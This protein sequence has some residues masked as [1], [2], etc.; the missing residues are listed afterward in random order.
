[1]KPIILLDIDDTVVDM[2]T[3]WKEWYYKESGY[4]L[5]ID[6]D[7]FAFN[8]QQSHVDPLIFWSNNTLYDNLK[9]HQKAIDFVNT[10]KDKFDIVFCSWCYVEHKKSKEDFI[11]KYFGKYPFIDTKYKEYV[12]CDFM[13]DDRISF[14]KKSKEFNRDNRSFIHLNNNHNQK[15]DFMYLDWDQIYNFFNIISMKDN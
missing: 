13:I 9:P 6:N 10:F 7:V 1:M 4:E 12:K 14:L 3:L 5:L 8:T 2:T 15:S 11:K